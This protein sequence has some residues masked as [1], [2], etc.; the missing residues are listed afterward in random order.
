MTDEVEPIHDTTKGLDEKFCSS[1]GSIIK[2]A[3]EI[4]PKCGVRQF[5]QAPV[6]TNEYRI[7]KPT[8]IL[9][10]ILLGAFGGQFFYL[11]KYG[12]G[13]ACLLLCWTFIPVILAVVDFFIFISK[14]EN[15]INKLYMEQ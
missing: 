14:S 11:R 9:I 4:C 1:C 7:D 13:V 2:I 8:L 10:T 5:G 3:A 15:E 12:S 6:S